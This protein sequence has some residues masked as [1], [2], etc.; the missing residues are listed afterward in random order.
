M[1]NPK[2]A[3]FAYAL[4]LGFILAIA[5]YSPSKTLVAASAPVAAPAAD[6]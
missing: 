2:V 6:R 1:G 3:I 5:L 4:A